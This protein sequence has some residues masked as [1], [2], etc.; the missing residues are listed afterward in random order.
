MLKTIY[1]D[2]NTIITKHAI[3]ILLIIG[4]YCYNNKNITPYNHI[5][6][7]YARSGGMAKMAMMNNEISADMASNGRMYVENN[8]IEI[9]T[10]NVEKTKEKIDIEL[11][12]INGKLESLYSNKYY[13]KQ[14]FNITYRIPNDKLNAF[15]D[16]LKIQ[17]KVKNQNFSI[18]EVSKEYTNNENR[19]KSLTKRKARLEELLQNKTS[20]A[21]NLL[22]L[23]RELNSIQ[24]QIMYLE[25]TLKSTEQDI[26]FSVVKLTI[27][28]EKYIIYPDGQE[29][30]VNSAF[31]KVVVNFIL[32][33]Q[34]VA[35]FL[36][37]IAIFSP[38]LLLAWLIRKLF[39]K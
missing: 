26:K 32:F 29:W 1:K 19:M 12:K 2:F 7:N 4:Y 36:L 8:S 38:Y 15:I 28:P 18:N 27:V 37:Y 34:N 10:K 39:K 35:T 23:E 13:N 6:A 22:N 31:N 5:P 16:F 17:G 3:I 24:D 14:S 11:K 25:N 20:T 30:S 21:D 33:S 9:A